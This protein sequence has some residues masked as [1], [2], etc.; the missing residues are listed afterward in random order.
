[1][2]PYIEIPPVTLTSGLV[3]QPFGLLVLMGCVVGILA[4]MWY[5]KSRDLNTRVLIGALPWALIPGFA[6]SHL[7]AIY[8]YFP[9]KGPL[10]I[11]ELLDLANGMS[12]F[13]GFLGGAVGTMLY[14]R[15][16]QSPALPYVDALVFGFT[17]GWF[18][19]RLGCT[20]AHD[21]PGLP[22]E[23]FLTVA[24]PDGAR[25]DLGFYEWLFTVA[26]CGLLLTLRRRQIPPGALTGLICSL[27]APARFLLDFLRIDDRLYFGLTP[28]QYLAFPLLIVGLLLLR[29]SGRR[30][31]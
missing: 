7:A 17:F 28:G 5:A 16:V 27:Y 25:H 2:V 15:K 11:R 14:L 9:E 21:H 30:H 12:S 26:L 24:Y 4:S 10:D 3:L 19:G 8:L 13:G 29:G 1:M 31:Q 6:L 18:F 22:G 20:I 23:F